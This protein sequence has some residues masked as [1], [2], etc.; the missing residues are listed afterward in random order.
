MSSIL[1]KGTSTTPYLYC[2]AHP[3]MLTDPIGKDIVV[4]NYGKDLIHQ[5]LA[6]LIQD[7]NGKWQ[8]Y[9]VNGDNVYISGSHSG[10][11]QFNDVAVGSWDTPEEFLYS[12]YNVRDDDSKED[13][14]K[15]HFGFEEGYQIPTSPEQDAIM[16]SS[17][18]K[19]GKSEYDLIDNNCATAVQQA[20]IEAGIPVSKPTMVES[21]IPMSTPFGIVNVFNGYKMKCEILITPHS[22]FRSIMKWNPNGTYL[23]K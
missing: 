2:S 11:R 14:S 8:Y 12:S 10:G 4:L 16:R 3:V 22:A 9:S 23:Q 17:F 5:H 7:E 21:F 18:S 1:M 19:A 20:M 6:M 13:V 15:N